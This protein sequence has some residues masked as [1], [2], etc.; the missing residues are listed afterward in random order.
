M[1]DTAR[2]AENDAHITVLTLQDEG[3]ALREALLSHDLTEVRFRAR[4]MARLAL[5]LGLTSVQRAA[6]QVID[7]MGPEGSSPRW[8]YGAAIFALSDALHAV[9]RPQF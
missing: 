8:G 1:R 7:Q 3:D 5:V 6:T 4:E 2:M 9:E